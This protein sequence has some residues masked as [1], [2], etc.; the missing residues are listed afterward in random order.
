R[1][2]ELSETGQS[3]LTLTR[4]EAQ[5]LLQEADDWRLTEY[6]AGGTGWNRWHFYSRTLGAIW[7]GGDGTYTWYPSITTAD[8]PEPQGDP[9]TDRDRFAGPLDLDDPP[10]RPERP[11]FDQRDHYSGFGRYQP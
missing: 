4:D 5:A 1:S 9:E 2:F 11:Y 3:Y 7:R 6:P 8:P 10:E